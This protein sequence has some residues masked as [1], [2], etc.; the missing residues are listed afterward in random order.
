[1]PDHGHDRLLD[2]I[3]ELMPAL[4][5]GL[6]ALRHAGRHLHSPELALR[7]AEIASAQAPLAAGLERFR[8]EDWPAG[9]ADFQRAVDE[10]AQRTLAGLADF[11]AAPDSINPVMAAYRALG[12]QWRALEALYPVAAM[13]PP[14]G[15]YFLNDVG[16]ADQRLAALLAEADHGRADVGVMHAANETSQRGGF[17]LYVPEYQRAETPMP[18][19]VALHG[20]SGHGRGFLW[21]WLRDARSS[22]CLLIAPT[23][24]QDTWSLMGPDLDSG[25]LAAM[26][27]HV[28]EQW[29]IDRSRVLLT[30]MSDGAT[31]S[32]VA[33]LHDGS[34]FTHL[35]P[36]SGTFHPMLLDGASAARLAG[37]PVYLVHG[38]LDWMFPVDFAR[39]ARDALTAA[40]AA[41]SY[42]ELE[43]LS[44]T[45]PV[46][47]NARI[48]DWFMR[49][50]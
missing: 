20:G 19:I 47:E 46:E 34:P 4:L 26:I 42:R 8:A 21:T 33:G 2:A 11:V 7:A 39:L 3:T 44:H 28:G 25:N 31:F 30:G 12:Q 15:R 9:L 45:Y 37:L 16:R 32:W 27:D 50:R 13:L 14:V 6:E 18:L 1:M 41:V 48:L 23:S 36:I 5:G 22:G 17:S 24:R 29:P 10:S 49:P 43:D 38:A 35:A 40:G